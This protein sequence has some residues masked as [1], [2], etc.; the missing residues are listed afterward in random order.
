M[1]EYS[2]CDYVWDFSEGAAKVKMGGKYGFVDTTGHEIVPCKYD[3][4]FD[5]QE[6]MARVEWGGKWGYIDKSGREVIPCIYCQA[7]D[8]SDGWAKVGLEMSDS[9]QREQD[10]DVPF[11][12]TEIKSFFIDKTGK[13][14]LTA[15]K[16][17]FVFKEGLTT[18]KTGFVDKEG[19]EV[20]SCKYD[21]VTLF[22]D[23]M[24]CVCEDHL[25]PEE[26]QTDEIDYYSTYGYIDKNGREVTPCKYDD[27]NSFHEG[28][29]LVK[30]DGKFGFID[31]TGCEVIPLQYDSAYDFHDGLACVRKQSFYGFIDKTGLEVLNLAKH[32]IVVAGSFSERLAVALC[33][34]GGKRGYIDKTGKFVIPCKYDEASDFHDGCALIHDGNDKYYFIDKKGR[35]INISIQVDNTPKLEK[36]DDGLPF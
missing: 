12:P 17:W 21:G 24:A 19:R 25:L 3:D 23:G 14:V 10:E 2:K 28:L 16:D 20:I 11:P 7:Y 6:G 13:E 32:D 15:E 1:E 36:E 18:S 4:A 8:F 33:E 22:C 31:K 27:A 30:L 26:E 9:N 35:E 29:A 5:F 34:P